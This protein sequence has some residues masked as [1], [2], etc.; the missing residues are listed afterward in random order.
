MPNILG[1]RAKI[2]VFVP[3]RNTVVE[4][5]GNPSFS[6]SGHTS[7]VSGSDD[8]ARSCNCPTPEAPRVLSRVSR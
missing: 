7:I 3:S 4:H 2:G 5:D 1:Y 6:I 8:S